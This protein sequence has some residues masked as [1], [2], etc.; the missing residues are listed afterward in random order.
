MSGASSIGLKQI[1][2][3][4][5]EQMLA[6]AEDFGYS[7]EALSN[8]ELYDLLISVLDGHEDEDDGEELDFS[9]D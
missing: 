4:S 3:M 1:D 7:T 6:M 5:I 8:D 9:D 2:G